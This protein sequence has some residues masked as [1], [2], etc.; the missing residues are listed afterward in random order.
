[1]KSETKELI[2]TWIAILAIFIFLPILLEDFESNKPPYPC[3]L[4]ISGKY[5][6]TYDY[7]F[8]EHRDYYFEFE[9]NPYF[10][11]GCINLNKSDYYKYEIG[12][13]YSYHWVDEW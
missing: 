12:D 10:A 5:I 4:T 6:K 9:E 11:Y 1:M 13:N 7:Y 2:L 8:F 3:E